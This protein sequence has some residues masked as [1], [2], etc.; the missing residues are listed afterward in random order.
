MTIG[1]NVCLPVKMSRVAPANASDSK[2]HAEPAAQSEVLPPERCALEHPEDLALALTGWPPLKFKEAAVPG[3]LAS[4]T[5]QG[6]DLP[7]PPERTRDAPAPSSGQVQIP[8]FSRPLVSSQRPLE[9]NRGPLPEGP[10]S[11]EL[12]ASNRFSEVGVIFPGTNNKVNS[13]AYKLP[14]VGRGL[15][16]KQNNEKLFHRDKF[17]GHCGSNNSCC[18]CVLM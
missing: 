15:E 12:V 5:S 17:D 8:N 2:C 10:Y 1:W 16:G 13:A 7:K 9:F 14:R 11:P 18:S 6:S 4:Q 3:S